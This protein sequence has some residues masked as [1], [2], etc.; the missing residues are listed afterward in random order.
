MINEWERRLLQEMED[1]TSAEDPAFALRL[2]GAGS[3]LFT[4]DEAWQRWCS[5][6]RAGTRLPLLF[7]LVPLGLVCFDLKVSSLGLSFLLWAIIVATRWLLWAQRNGVIPVPE[8]P[9]GRH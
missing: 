2:A 8:Q 3:P 1:Q 7:L 6:W 5:A 4:D 9:N